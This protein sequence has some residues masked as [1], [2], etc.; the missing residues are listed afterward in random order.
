MSKRKTEKDYHA[1]AESRGFKWVGEVLPKNNK[2]KTWWECCKGHKF[3]MRYNNVQQGNNCSVCSGNI[4]KIE[5]DYH[6]LAEK[7]GFKW[8]GQL[9]PDNVHIT[10]LWE[11]K[12]EHTWYATF[13]NIGSWG[14]PVCARQARK[15]EEDYHGLAVV[16]EFKWIG[17]VLPKNI[18]TKTWWECKIGHRWESVYNNIYN[19]SGCPY[20]VNLINGATV[21]KPQQ[22]VNEMLSG[23]LNY[24][25]NR[26]RI[27][28]AIMRNSQKIAVEYDC[29]YW[30]QGKEEHDAKRDKYLVSRD[31]KILHIKSSVLLP[32]RKQLNT[33][34]K[35]L[36]DTNEVIHN[37]YLKDWKK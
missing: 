37:L 17:K 19:G 22:K 26:Y 24:P 36:V 29:W 4:R 31:W 13:H 27:D 10:T 16:R 7:Q 33:A 25:E 14:C 9:L 30:H 15:T 21:S 8:V 2:D 1:L 32:T 23:I 28:V 5:K 6:E 20:C 12:K 35:Q 18:R 34:I 3:E 11:C